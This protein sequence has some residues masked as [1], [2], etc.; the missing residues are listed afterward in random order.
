MKR[1]IISKKGSKFLNNHVIYKYIYIYIYIERER[2]IVIEQH[3]AAAAAVA[4]A[5]SRPARSAA[6]RPGWLGAAPTGLVGAPLLLPLLL[7]LYVV[8]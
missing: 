1:S 4:A 7:P 2:D 6:P 5:S 3:A 8:L